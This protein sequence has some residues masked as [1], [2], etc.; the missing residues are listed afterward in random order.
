MKLVK[1]LGDSQEVLRAFPDGVRHDLGVQLGRVQRGEEPASWKPMKAIGV[2]V[3]ELRVRDE[4]GA[5]R[6]IYTMT[7]GD[8]I[9][10]L[11]VFQKKSQATARRDIELAKARY[12]MLT[13]HQ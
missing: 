8:Y 7:I 13:G 4:T 1:F 12:R 2:G 3:R 9:Y 11:H 5:F 6:L 10:V